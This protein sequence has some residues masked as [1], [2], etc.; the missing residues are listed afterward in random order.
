VSEHIVKLSE[1]EDAR[2]QDVLVVVM[3]GLQKGARYSVRPKDHATCH[4]TGR[5]VRLS[6]DGKTGVPGVC[7]C[8]VRPVEREVGKGVG[9]E[10]Q[11][12]TPEQQ[13]KARRGRLDGEL[14][15]ARTALEELLQK[16]DQTVA[17]CVDGAA[18]AR[19]KALEF[20]ERELQQAAAIGVTRDEL[21]VS[22]VRLAQAEEALK[23]ARLA[24][25]HGSLTLKA[26]EQQVEGQGRQRA[27]ALDT[28]AKLEREAERIR[29]RGEH[30]SRIEG[31]RRAVAKLE[32]EIAKLDTPAPV[33]A[34]P[35]PQPAT[36]A[37]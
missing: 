16:R 28:A 23:A 7:D 18:A 19:G 4:R 13:A 2:D 29:E 31:L 21:A 37:A 30:A 36:E 12:L 3:S 24:V 33:A 20:R 11:W 32:A 22:R 15:D 9:L 25:E 1:N 34:A 8:I 10:A 14:R 26:A 35:E 6:R 17:A 5:T 27:A